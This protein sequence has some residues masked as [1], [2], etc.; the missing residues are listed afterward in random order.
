MI[1]EE[2]IERVFNWLEKTANEAAETRAARSYMEEGRKR[3]K[4]IIM[5]EHVDMPVSA[6]ERE[7]YA[8][9]RYRVHLEGL[10]EAIAADEKIKWLRDTALAKIDAWRTAEANRRGMGRVG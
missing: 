5:S 9:D 8:D 3:L 4:A 2:D 1:T 7:A 6:Q 10:R